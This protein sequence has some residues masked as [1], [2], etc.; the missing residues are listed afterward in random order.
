MLKRRAVKNKTN[1]TFTLTMAEGCVFN[2]RRSVMILNTCASIVTPASCVS[3]YKSASSGENR[4]RLY[5]VVL[6][7]FS[8]MP[9]VVKG[10]SIAEFQV[11]SPLNIISQ[12][13]QLMKEKQR[14]I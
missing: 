8:A 5:S 4:L 12:L 14:V 1:K 3:S 13:T 9:S 6:M 10:D 7:L 11:L 2:R